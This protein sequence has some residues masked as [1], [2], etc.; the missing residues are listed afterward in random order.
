MVLNVF[1]VQIVEYPAKISDM[2]TAR[3]GCGK[4]ELKRASLKET[5]R[6]IGSNCWQDICF[7]SPIPM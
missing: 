7:S 3:A 6:N 1:Q 4:K 2:E 5:G